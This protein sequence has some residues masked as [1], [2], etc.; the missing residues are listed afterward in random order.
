MGLIAWSNKYSVGVKKLDDQHMDIVDIL[1]ELHAVM[2]KGQAQSVADALLPKLQSVTRDHFA[3]EERLME[4]TKY[5]GLAEQR[6][7]HGA[8]LGKIDDFVARYQQ[9]DNTMYP[10]LL[11]FMR[12]WLLSHD[13][14]V[15]QKYTGWFNS[16]GIS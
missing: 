7:E 2:L 6:T 13:L 12:D 16:N 4:S 14:T 15:D 10:E 9:G 3:T 1:N 8:L 11:Y 5:P